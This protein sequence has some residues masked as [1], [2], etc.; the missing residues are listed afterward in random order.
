MKKNWRL[1]AYLLTFSSFPL[2]AV[3]SLDDKETAAQSISAKTATNP[4]SMPPQKP[5]EETIQAQPIITPAVAPHILDGSDTYMT[6]DFLWWKTFVGSMEYAFTGVADNS[7]FV[8][9]GSSTGKGKAQKPDFQ[10]EPGIKAG[11]GVNFNH[12]GW[13]LYAQYTFL[14][15]PKETNSIA[16]ISGTGASSL[17]DIAY[18]NGTDQ[19]LSL[20]NASCNWE[21]DFNIIDL[22]LGRDY[23]ISRHLTLRPSTG[24]KTGWVN[25]R[26]TIS[27]VPTTTVPVDASSG[28]NR[29]TSV[30]LHQRQNMWGLGIRTGLNVG[31]HVSKNWSFYNDFAFTAL[32][33]D[34]SIQQK[35]SMNETV[36][37]SMTP[38]F[39]NETI[40]TVIPVVE[41]ALGISYITWWEKGRYR[42]EVR[43]GWEEQ[44]WLDF[45]HFTTLGG[46][47]NLTLQ[48]LT[49]KAILN[50]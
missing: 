46:T 16:A 10:F 47:G 26:T 7:A 6:F 38:K 25:E 19:T 21:Q 35:Q 18:N 31:W 13:D 37:G 30:V 15:G 9:F 22:E 23:F 34:F 5:E 4:K 2:L 44:I 28:S 42:F 24:F 1:L 48:G 3:P 14:A 40:K 8:P 50:F 12:D 11:I 27:M 32:W 36:Y 43:G 49:L 20:V 39:V 45:N 41:A 33:A 29:P 17:Q